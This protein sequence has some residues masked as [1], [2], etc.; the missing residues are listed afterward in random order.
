[1][2]IFLEI[3]SLRKIESTRKYRGSHLGSIVDQ[4]ALKWDSPKIELFL[5]T[6]VIYDSEDS[7]YLQSTTKWLIPWKDIP[8]KELLKKLLHCKFLVEK[9]TA[10]L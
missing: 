5:I 4:I 9:W 3:L 6:Q 2:S 1:M 10:P 7:F 8:F